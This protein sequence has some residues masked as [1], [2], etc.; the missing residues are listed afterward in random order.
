MN[1]YKYSS[2]LKLRPAII[3]GILAIDYWVCTNGDIWSSKSANGE[4]K[5][6]GPVE[7]NTLVSS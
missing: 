1:N 7:S 4:F 5:N 3:N 2:G 6:S